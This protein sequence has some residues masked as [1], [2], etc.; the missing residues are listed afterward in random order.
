MLDDATQRSREVPAAW[1]YKINYNAIDAKSKST[2]IHHR[3]REKNQVV[4][5]ARDYPGSHIIKKVNGPAVGSYFSDKDANQKKIEE[6]Q[7]VPYSRG[8]TCRKTLFSRGKRRTFVEEYAE[9]KKKIPGIGSY[10][11]TEKSFEKLSSPPLSLRR[12]R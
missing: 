5:G 7:V 8:F 1:K 6:K 12:L 11:N 10:K 3:E 2:K 9:K 4:K